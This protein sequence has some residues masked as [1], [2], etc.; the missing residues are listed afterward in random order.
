MGRGPSKIKGVLSFMHTANFTIISDF[1]NNL[2][3]ALS[4]LAALPAPQGV[5]LQQPRPAVNTVAHG[6]TIYSWYWTVHIDFL[7]ILQ[8]PNIRPEHISDL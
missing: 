5:T 8:V 1:Q 6:A 2:Y 7:K 3:P 4:K